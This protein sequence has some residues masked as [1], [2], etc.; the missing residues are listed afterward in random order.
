[1]GCSCGAVTVTMGMAVMPQDA[2]TPEELFRAA[3]GAMYVAKQ[4]GRN[5]YVLAAELRSGELNGAP[6]TG[7]A[8]PQ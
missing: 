4:R 8:P 1:M 6:Q 3:D 2:N 5:T 7:A